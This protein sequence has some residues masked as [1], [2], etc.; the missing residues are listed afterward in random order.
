MR[1]AVLALRQREA[2]QVV[3][4]VPIGSPEACAALA[5]EADELICL[6]APMNFDAV[7]QAYDDFSQT[8][9]DEVQ[10]LLAEAGCSRGVT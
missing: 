9:D 3:V 10:A 2:A 5:R 1:A 8:T 6:A 7:G 4:A